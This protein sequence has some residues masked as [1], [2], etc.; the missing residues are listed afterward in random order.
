MVRRRVFAD[1]SADGT[2]GVP[3]GMKVDE[4][5]RVFCTGTGGVWVFEPDGSRIGIFE[6]PEVC[7]NIAFGGPDM[8]TL[9]LTASTSVYTV[10]VKVPGL[11]HPWYKVRGS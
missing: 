7:A 11:P 8:R 10:R 9:L 1:M 3:D 2:N 4:A 6:T 5:G